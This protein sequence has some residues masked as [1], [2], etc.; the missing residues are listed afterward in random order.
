[1]SLE[2]NGTRT[3]QKPDPAGKRRVSLISGLAAAV[4]VAGAVLCL[5]LVTAP[6]RFVARA[7]FTIDWKTMPTEP[8]F[9]AIIK[10]GDEWR[11]MVN[12]ELTSLT[13]TEEQIGDFLDRAGDPNGLPTDRTVVVPKL[14]KWLGVTVANEPGE[15]DRVTIQMRDGDPKL[16]EAIVKA[17]LQDDVSRIQVHASKRSLFAVLPAPVG[18]EDIDRREAALREEQR[19]LQSTNS[20]PFEAEAQQRY[21]AI[22]AERNKLELR[23]VETASGFV[24]NAAGMACNHSIQI[25]EDAHVLKRSAGRGMRVLFAAVCGGILAGIAGLLMNQ[26]KWAVT[27]SKA[28][29]TG[30]PPAFTPR[31]S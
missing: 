26:I 28:P 21:E 10:L 30:N 24:A 7:V 1:M 9:G 20:R 17:V 18:L 29:A 19:Q 25:V 14:R 16:A 2:R 5:G 8:T 3:G 6:P 31:E 13:R 22:L 15:V 11:R 4:V 23:H 27:A 12:W